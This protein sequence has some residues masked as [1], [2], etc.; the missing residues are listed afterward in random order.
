V[1]LPA[2]VVRLGGRASREIGVEQLGN[3]DV[4]GRALLLQTGA[5]SRWGTPGY[6]ERS[7][8]LTE[9]GAR[10]L[11]EEGA[12]LVGIDAVDID[13]FEPSSEGRR[14]VHTVLLAA[15]IPVVENLTG[16]AQLPGT[17]AR[18]TAA[19]P[20]LAGVGT[21]PVRAYASFSANLTGSV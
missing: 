9:A 11:V 8:Y 21:F 14:P 10:W 6:A 19:P 18:F 2:V 4:Q 20:M 7:P 15:G 12:R 5:D 17:G 1:D 3:E 13:D 16:L